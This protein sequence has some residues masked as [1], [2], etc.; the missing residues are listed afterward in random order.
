MRR[1][2]AFARLGRSLPPGMFV[3]AGGLLVAGA[4][5]YGFLGFTAHELGP[6]RYSSLAVLWALLFLVAPGVFSPLEQ[7]VGRA[8]AGRK[9]SGLGGRPVIARAA[10][11][12]GGAAV[13]LVL[14]AVAASHPLAD[15]LFSGDTGLVAAFAL[16]LPGYAG[17][18]LL[19][20]V[21]AG[22]GRFRRYGVL[23]G[24]EGLAR[25]A[26]ALA[27]V[28][29]GAATVGRF[30]SAIAVAPFAALIIVL[31]RD[32]TIAA[33]GPPAAWAELSSALGLL[34]IGSILANL[35]V[36]GAPLLV[37]I[38][39]TSREHAVAGQFLAGL[40]LVRAPLYLWQAVMAALLPGLA[41]AVEHEDRAL[42]RGR[43]LSLVV[44]AVAVAV[45]G[46]GLSGTIGPSILHRVF[47]A[48]F[49]LGQVDLM[50]LS[51]AAGAFMLAQVLSQGLIALS[52]YGT[53]M[54]GWGV[55]AILLPAIVF[56][57][58][59]GLLVRSEF[60]MLASCTTAAVVMAAALMSRLRSSAATGSASGP[61]PDLSVLPPRSTPDATP[62]SGQ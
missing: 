9:A 50:L 43:L 42:F 57:P 8:L 53:S 51:G 39:A 12:G 2:S 41:T 36:N 52:R 5:I 35:L 28:A 3:V 20:G 34:L 13:V 6:V 19:R 49:H 4:T 7:E 40:L 56:A 11:A 45:I 48:G 24:A 22:S 29:L 15:Q 30:A 17:F 46:I 62:P 23:V 60:A 16:A 18:Y 1:R 26:A 31:P 14:A 21:L 44:I 58:L 10:V 37:Q 55:G 38:A 25:L 33:P 54:W 47:G 59:G 27:V 61:A 32:R